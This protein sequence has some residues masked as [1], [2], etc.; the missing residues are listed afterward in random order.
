MHSAD[1]QPLYL[2]VTVKPD[3]SGGTDYTYSGGSFFDGRPYTSFIDDYNSTNQLIAQYYYN[4]ATLYIENTV[5]A[6]GSGGTD[7]TY[8]GG[9]F[10]KGLPYTSY[11]ADYNGNGQLISRSEYNGAKLYLADTVT[12][13]GKGGTDTIYKGGSFF[14]GLPYTSYTIDDNSSGQ[15]ISRSEYNG[16]TLYLAETITPDGKGGTDQTFKGGSF[17]NGLPYTSYTID[18]NSKGQEIAQ[19]YYH[20]ATLYLADTVTPDGKGG[21]DFT[22]KGGSYFKGQPYTSYTIDDNSSGQQIA[23]SY[24]NGATLYLAV[25]LKPDGSGGTDDVDTGGSFFNGLPYTSETNDYNSSGDLIAQSFHNGATL[26]LADTVA[27]DGKGGT[28][29]TFK[30]GSSFNGLPYT[31]Y[32]NDYNGSGQLTGQQFYSGSTL[33]LA[34]TVKPDGSGGSDYTYSGGSYFTQPGLGYSS[35]VDDFNS[36]GQLIS[37]HFIV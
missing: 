1:N 33:Y 23:E 19:S 6:D 30:G 32:V 27:S 4:G 25:T 24:Y 16:A 9:S 7:Y 22:Y 11:V 2:S 35:Y 12:P 34:D 37:Q 18:D 29:Y 28:D 13:D 15:M 36:K 21:T 31:S 17:F 8:K 20:G 14:N 5:K 26:Y 3:G 10:F